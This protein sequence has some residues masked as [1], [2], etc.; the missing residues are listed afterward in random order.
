MS[1]LTRYRNKLRHELKRRRQKRIEGG[2]SKITRMRVKI[3]K[4]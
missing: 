2:E 4:E 1:Q 3:P